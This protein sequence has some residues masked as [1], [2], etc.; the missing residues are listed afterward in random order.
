M[1][2]AGDTVSMTVCAIALQSSPMRTLNTIVHDQKKLSNRVRPCGF[3]WPNIW[4]PRSATM[5]RNRPRTISIGHTA[6]R[7]ATMFSKTSFTHFSFAEPRARRMSRMSRNTRNAPTLEPPLS[8]SLLKLSTSSYVEVVT[9]TAS[10]TFEGSP[11]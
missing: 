7:E 4:Q 1:I 2:A 9:M 6:L 10:N 3:I 11:R 8:S 5:N